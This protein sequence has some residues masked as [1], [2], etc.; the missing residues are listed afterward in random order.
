MSTSVARAYHH[1]DL[2]R[3]LID[4]GV[5]LVAEEGNWDFSL[6][7][8]ARRAGVSHN[9]PYNHFADRRALL[10]AV[11]AQEFGG[12]R[13][14][15][16]RAV[17]GVRKAETALLKA[18]LAYVAF[19]L[20][21]PAR[22]RLM[23]GSVLVD[24]VEGKPQEVTDAGTAAKSVVAELVRRGAESGELA[25]APRDPA[26]LELTVFSVWSAVHGMTILLIDG[27]TGCEGIAPE[28][29]ATRLMR[30][31]FKGLRAR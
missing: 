8:V 21:N 16:T 18:G 20:E 31:L 2:R 9:A 6:R 24:P 26:A 7:E 22:Y 13:E 25:V 10:A 1:G 15:L 5:A 27:I 3:A 14:R 12:L 29:L 19:A 23:F 4:A 30:T 17:A 11:A 28:E